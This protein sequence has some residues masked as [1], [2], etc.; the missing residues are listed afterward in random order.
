[1]KLFR[2]RQKISP[3]DV[4]ANLMQTLEFV[5]NLVLQEMASSDSPRDLDDESLA[6]VR[7]ASAHAHAH[8]GVSRVS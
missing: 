6:H 2:R 7:D 8:A 5:D 1:M 3:A 4:T